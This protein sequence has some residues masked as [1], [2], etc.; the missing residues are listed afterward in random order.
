MWR[1][2]FDELR[3]QG[4]EGSALYTSLS[5][6]EQQLQTL[7]TLQTSQANV[8]RRADDAAQVAPTPAR[9]AILGLA[10]GLV[11][12]VGLAFGI[13]ALDTRIRSA[14]A[15]GE[16]LGLPML[17]RVPPPPRTLAKENRLVMLAQP[18]GP[19]AEA[20]RMLRTNLEFAALEGDRV[21]S[22]S[23]RARS[24]RR[25]SRRQRR[26]S[27]SSRPAPAAGSASSI[28]TC[29][30]PISIAS[31]HCSTR[32]GS[33]TSPSGRSRSRTRC[34]GSTSA[35]GAPA[36]NGS[37]TLQA[38]GTGERGSLDVLTRGRCHPTRANSSAPGSSRRSSA[39]FAPRYDLV[40]LDTPPLLRVSDAMTLSAH[41]DGILVVTQVER[42]AST[43]AGRAAAATRDR[44]RA[45]TRA[46]SRPAR[47]ATQ[48]ATEQATATRTAAT[49]TEPPRTR[50]SV[51][52]GN[53]C[54]S[55]P[56]LR[57]TVEE[58]D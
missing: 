11:L 46:T 25:A 44:A 24:R 17:A 27:R 6:K 2:R 21:H 43:D 13:D 26:T 53:G 57:S 12:G 19:H 15:I 51:S 48:P 3:A 37:V 33:P 4:Q 47:E 50:R 16:R 36:T 52:Q 42:R 39:G 23:S 8:T 18:T 49:A 45:E 56:V 28:S 38:N 32:R 10:L 1:P 34:T 35:W 55:G 7:L 31:S 9:N 54:G 14:G 41:A 22:S 20:F 30:V 29:D 58:L 5:E 40:I